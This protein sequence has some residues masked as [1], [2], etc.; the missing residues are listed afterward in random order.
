M[1]LITNGRPEPFLKLGR[2][3]WFFWDCTSKCKSACKLLW[4]RLIPTTLLPTPGTEQRHTTNMRRV[5]Q[6]VGLLQVPKYAA[7]GAP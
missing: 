2:F 5:A 4:L 7:K 6:R 1:N 3:W